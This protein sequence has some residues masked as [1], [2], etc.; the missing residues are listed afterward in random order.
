MRI[1]KKQPNLSSLNS[2]NLALYTEQMDLLR[3]LLVRHDTLIQ[4][5]TCD[6]QSL[7][8]IHTECDF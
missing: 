2:F 1:T 6:L 8:I 7:N 5:L 3:K 4:I